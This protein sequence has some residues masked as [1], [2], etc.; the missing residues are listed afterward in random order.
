MENQ[1]LEAIKSLQE[2]IDSMREE[3]K[4]K[5]ENIDKK[6]QENQSKI[7][8]QEKKWIQKEKEERRKNVIIY[9]IEEKEKNIS[10]LELLCL[11]IINEELKVTVSINEIDRIIRLGSRENRN[12][13]ILI[14]FLSTR[15]AF[16]LLSN[17]KNLKGSK[18]F[19]SED[20]PKEVQIK[21]KQLLPIL[22]YLRGTGAHTLI[23]YDKLVVDGT[24]LKE[25]DIETII[26]E[27]NSK[28]RNRSEDNEEPNL[29]N[30]T[31]PDNKKPKQKNETN[32]T[33]R[34]PR[35]NSV[36]NIR[37]KINNQQVSLTDMFKKADNSSNDA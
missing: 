1:I 37:S 19:I 33:K 20:L 2:T 11:K 12:K 10:E 28:K 9:G 6:I 26:E 8:E 36:G 25:E 13:P 35:V 3:M 5:N 16:E 29:N 15:K 18:I 32:D 24:V 4:T 27:I 14:K 21:R 30:V 17:K 31:W 34:R 23:K 7:S 22:K